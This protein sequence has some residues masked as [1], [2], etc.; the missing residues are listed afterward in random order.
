VRPAVAVVAKPAFILTI[1]FMNMIMF[2]VIRMGMI[3]TILYITPP[4]DGW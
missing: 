1:T 3:M 4:M 2:T